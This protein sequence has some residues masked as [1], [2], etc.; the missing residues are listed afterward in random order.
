MYANFLPIYI[1]LEGPISIFQYFKICLISYDSVT[2]QLFENGRVDSAYFFTES[3]QSP[4]LTPT[5]SITICN[6]IIL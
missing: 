5:A 4:T 2:T 3:T 6:N 1:L